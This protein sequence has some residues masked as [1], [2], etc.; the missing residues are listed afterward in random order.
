LLL[1]AG[2]T[3][4]ARVAAQ[5]GP[6]GVAP[7]GAAPI[8]SEPAGSDSST[9]SALVVAD[10]PVK[11][12]WKRKTLGKGS[13]SSIAVDAAG[14]PHVVFEQETPKYPEGFVLTYARA[15]GAHWSFEEIK[16]GHGLTSHHRALA[17][18]ADGTPHVFHSADAPEGGKNLEHAFRTD[19]GWQWE[20]IE[21]GGDVPSIAIDDEGYLHVVHIMGGGLRYVRQTKTGW[22]AE[23][24]AQ[25]ALSIG[26]S[27]LTLH[28][29][30]VYA[31]FSDGSN[32]RKLFLAVRDGVIWSVEEVDEGFYGSTAFDLDGTLHL[33]YG[34]ATELWHA[35][36]G[37]SGWEQETLIS[38]SAVFG[39]AVPPGFVSIG[40]APA[41]VADVSGRLHLVNGLTLSKGEAYGSA[42]LASTWSE[43]AWSPWGVKAGPLGTYNSIAVDT[44]GIA[45][46]TTRK[47][48]GGDGQAVVLAFRL[49]G[50]KLALKVVPPGSGSV[51]V[52][53]SGTVVTSKASLSFYP[54]SDVTLTAGA[55]AGF[56]F[57][58]W[59]GS[60]DGTGPEIVL[61]LV[62]NRKVVARFEPAP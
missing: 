33:A 50:A 43:G 13:A 40:E 30:K 29:G 55:E 8:V 28:D 37:E 44:N 35:W 47:A 9:T 53:P 12:K 21:A 62:K 11:L 48:T 39:E 19:D 7:I 36:L 18:G 45:H 60:V 16:P 49:K 22:E 24:V 3:A 59:D 20:T 41:L 32:P 34:G 56:V 6:D 46:L 14:N 38:Q 54:G 1:V 61:D 31:T 52:S 27:S 15:E 57:S 23:D 5:S 51:S 58:G 17:L 26:G 42:L 10:P 4:D 2:G 25:G